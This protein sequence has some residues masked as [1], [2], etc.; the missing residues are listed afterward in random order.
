[1]FPLLPSA[2][3]RID[4]LTV[5]HNADLDISAFTFAGGAF[6]SCPPREMMPRLVCTQLYWTPRCKMSARAGF[7]VY[8]PEFSQDESEKFGW[9]WA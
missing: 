9:I 8:R 2:C 1:M 5:C 7:E 4:Q 3:I 6:S